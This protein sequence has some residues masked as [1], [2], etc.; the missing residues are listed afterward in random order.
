MKR[1]RVVVQL[2]GEDSCHQT[3]RQG[4]L[5]QEEVQILQKFFESGPQ[6]RIKT[7][8]SDSESEESRVLKQIYFYD[9]ETD[10]YEHSLDTPKDYGTFED[11]A[12]HQVMESECY[13]C[14]FYGI[15]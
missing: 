10:Y 4:F 12:A 7:V 6:K 1:S 8:A 2:I 3:F 5:S 11:I 9:A 13:F 14:V 15:D